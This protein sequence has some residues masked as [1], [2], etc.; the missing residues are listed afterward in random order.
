MNSCRLRVP[1]P[2]RCHN[3]QAYAGS[4]GMQSPKESFEG[5]RGGTGYHS[6]EIYSPFDPANMSQPVSRLGTARQTSTTHQTYQSPRTSEAGQE[7][8]GHDGVLAHFSFA[9]AT[10]TTVVTTTT[11]TTT[12]FPPLVL[13]GPRHLEELDP[14]EYPLAITPTPPSLKR[15]CFD[16]GG[17]PTIFHEADHSAESYKTVSRNRTGFSCLRQSAN[18]TPP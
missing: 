17:R 10:T 3:P 9:P 7:A 13:K 11:T 5:I 6:S 14:K 16:V 1:V 18:D 8:F 12:T 2:R 15:F 4:E